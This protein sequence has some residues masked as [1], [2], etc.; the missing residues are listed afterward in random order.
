MKKNHEIRKLIKIEKMGI[1]GG[2]GTVH[3]DNWEGMVIFSRGAG[4]E[5]VSVSPLENYKIPTWDQMCA[6]KDIFWYEDEEAI[7]IH[8][9]KSEYVNNVSD[10][11][12]LWRCYYTKMPLP[13][14]VLVGLRQG[15]RREE[16]I[17]ELI[18]AYI[19]VGETPPM[20]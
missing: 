6:I 19:S 14:S 8:P 15:Q 12:H 20:I 11:L 16:F 5:H 18:Q 9:K 13:P 2:K 17:Q 7:Q 4:W 3:L 1:D 10:C